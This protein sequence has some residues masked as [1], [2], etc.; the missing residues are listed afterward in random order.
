MRASVLK[1]DSK[2]KKSVFFIEKWILK[3]KNNLE[4]NK[5]RIKVIAFIECCSTK[6]KIKTIKPPEGAD[7]LLAKVFNGLHFIDRN[8]KV[9]HIELN[10]IL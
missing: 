2:S 4:K 9:P 10:D 5:K 7:E 1:V 3:I 8:I 6:R